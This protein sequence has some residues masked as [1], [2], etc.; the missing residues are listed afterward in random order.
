MKFP[1][2]KARNQIA[3]KKGLSA[4][5]KKKKSKLLFHSR[6]REATGQG[7]HFRPRSSPLNNLRDFCTEILSIICMFSDFAIFLVLP[8]CHKQSI[9]S[10]HG[11]VLSSILLALGFV[12]CC[13]VKG[14]GRL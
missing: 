10:K 5:E 1:F 14:R 6:A 2:E 4:A 8:G 13:D 3:P 11:S 12:L 9:Q 7:L